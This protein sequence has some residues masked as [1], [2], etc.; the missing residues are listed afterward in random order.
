[1]TQGTKD[2]IAGDFHKVKGD[3]KQKAGQVTN[4][5]DLEAEGNV[6]NLA[7][8]VQKTVGRVEKVFEK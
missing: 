4:N 7:G 1:M 2:Q 5:P 6:E 3:I 8:H